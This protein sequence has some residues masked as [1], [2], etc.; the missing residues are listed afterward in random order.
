MFQNGSHQTQL[1]G[2]TALGDVFRAL[3]AVSGRQA[4]NVRVALLDGPVDTDHPSFDGANLTYVTGRDIGPPDEGPSYEHGTFVASILFGQP[5]SPT[6]GLTPAS[7]GVIVPIFRDDAFGKVVPCP[8]DKLAAAIDQALAAG[9]SVINISGGEHVPD[10]APSPALVAALDACDAQGAVVVAAVGNGGCLCPNLPAALSNV[11]AVG[12]MQIDGTPMALNNWGEAFAAHGILAPGENLIGARALGEV[13]SKSGTSFATAVVTG[14]I[15]ELVARFPDKP[16]KQVARVLLDTADAGTTTE[17]AD[18]SQRLFRGRLN[19]EAAIAELSK[20]ERME[21][22]MVDA[23]P[24]R[25]EPDADQTQTGLAPAACC[26][27]CAADDT[28]EAEQG[29]ATAAAGPYEMS[30]NVFALGKVGYDFTGASRR[31]GF[32]QLG[33]S[34]PDDPAELLAFLDEHP[35]FADRIL[36]TLSVGPTPLYVVRPQGAFAAET[37][38]KLRAMLGAHVSNV[39]ERVSLPGVLGG[40]AVLHGNQRVP[41]LIP[42][43][44]GMFSWSTEALVEEVGASEDVAAQM[45]NFLS[46]VY[47]ELRNTGVTGEHRALNYAATN[48]FAFQPIFSSAFAD[49]LELHTIRAEPSPIAPPGSETY[50]VV[51]EFFNPRNRTEQARRLN[52][53]T[54]DVSD[55]LP[56]MMGEPQTWHGY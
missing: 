7:E 10:Q 35:Y 20:S 32:V 21:T 54:I 9:A 3:Y 49:G 51:L 31:E 29:G 33:M 14:V 11:I 13:T 42:D 47:Y 43:I 15:A 41:F 26:D 4:I 18:Q 40:N 48:A 30:Q 34:N 19:V 5:E 46:R 38:G 12:A 28:K 8:Q 23:P 24:D 6:P 44:R 27:S 53:Y 22:P 17:N 1:A 45:R 55:V 2:L 37:Y 16:P 25:T 50:D 56:V 39:A 36:W 52:R